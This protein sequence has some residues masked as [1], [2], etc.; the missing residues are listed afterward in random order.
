MKYE[1]DLLTEHGTLIEACIATH[2]FHTLFFESFHR[3]YP[4]AKLVG[5][6]RHVK[7]FPAL[8]WDGGSIDTRLDEWKDLGVQMRIPAGA[9]FAQPADGNHFSCVFVFHEQSKTV[10]CDDTLMYFDPS[11]FSGRCLCCCMP[12]IG[13]TLKMHPT[14]F[15]DDVS[16][17]LVPMPE[18]VDQFLA[19]AQGLIA[20]WDFD[21]LVTAH[22]GNK[23]G[24]AKN[25]LRELL[26]S[27]SEP[28]AKLKRS[29]QDLQRKR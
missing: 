7:K 10:F 11:C 1:I 20:D 13:G 17:G 19:W 14:T 24:G 22:T 29:F 5:T 2:P 6:P 15:D 9:E 26:A 27:S 8:Q 21:N 18:S 12:C 25:M 16:S 23:I 4:K 28:F 3:L